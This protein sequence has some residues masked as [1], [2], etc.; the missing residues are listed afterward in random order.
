MLLPF[1][2]KRPVGVQT[3]LVCFNE[4]GPVLFCSE[5]PCF[6]VLEPQQLHLLLLVCGTVAMKYVEKLFGKLTICLGETFG[7]QVY[8]KVFILD[9]STYIYDPFYGVYLLIPIYRYG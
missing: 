7:Y 5:G 8:N 4:L 3:S 1:S 6:F 9:V 2:F